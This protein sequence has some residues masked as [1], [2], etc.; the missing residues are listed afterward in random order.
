MLDGKNTDFY[1][2]NAEEYIRKLTALDNEIRAAVDN[3]PRRTL[4]FADRF[5]AR[6]FAAEFGLSY[7]SAFPGCA[8]DAEPSAATV[9]ALIDLVRESRIPCVFHIELSDERMADT[10]CEATG[11]EKRLFHCCHNIS[12]RDFAA[13]ETYLSLMAKNTQAIKE[14]LS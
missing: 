11:A 6:Y 1:H 5:A 8:A 14:A 10:I 2:A 3:A 12:A 4:V 9:A 7:T 13:G